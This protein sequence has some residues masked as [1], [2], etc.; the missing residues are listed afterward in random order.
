MSIAAGLAADK[1]QPFQ[2]E[3]AAS[4]PSKQTNQNV[5]IAAV[6]YSTSEATK[7]PFGKT[8]PNKYGIL[9][10]LLV[11]QNDTKQTLSLERIRVEYLTATGD[12]LQSTPPRD[13]PYIHGTGRPDYRTSPIPTVGGPRVKRS[14]N[15][16][17]SEVI[18]VRAFSARMLPP[19]QQASGFFYFQIAH[20]PPSRIYVTGLREAAS[21]N[22]LFYFEIPVD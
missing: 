19:G 22:E 1:D 11:I 14:K 4:Y 15:A 7:S 5:T 21:G 12:K 17:K 2:V 10:V 16:L 18:D 6:P 13:V 9:P 3:P 20:R 8:D